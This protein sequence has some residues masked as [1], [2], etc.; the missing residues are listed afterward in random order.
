ML[1]PRPTNEQLMIEYRVRFRTAMKIKKGELKRPY[2]CEECNKYTHISAHHPDY[3]KPNLIQW[4][5]SKCHSQKRR[6]RRNIHKMR[7]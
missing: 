5:C 4:L 7:K 2:R 3:D 6:D 1:N